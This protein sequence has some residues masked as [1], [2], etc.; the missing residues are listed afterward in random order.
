M[1]GLGGLSDA[2]ISA[3]P[4][5]L[6][7]NSSGL[8]GAKPNLYFD[9]RFAD[10]TPVASSTATGNYAAANIADMRPY[11]WWKAAYATSYLTVN[12]GGMKSA[13]SLIIFGHNLYTIAASV[14]VRGS[15]DNFASSDVLVA[16]FTP[17]SDAV[18]IFSFASAIYPYWRLK[19]IT[20]RGLPTVAIALLGNKFE[21]PRRLPLGFDARG[22]DV[23]GI[24]NVNDNGHPLGDIIQYEKWKQKTLSFLVL[25]DFVRNTFEPVWDSHLRGSPFIFAWDVENYPTDIKLLKGG[26]GFSAPRRA[27]LLC[28]LSFDVS[29]VVT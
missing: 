13:D 2:P 12:C 6:A 15:S 7:G 5:I 29:G 26:R 18:V 20:P 16:G 1:L 21:M 8:P 14:E 4:V 28:D 24:S 11:T 27:G 9:N 3:L 23:V 22:R 17:I 25:E 10:A 19:F